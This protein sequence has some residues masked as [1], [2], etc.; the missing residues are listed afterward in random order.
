MITSGKTLAELAGFMTEFPQVLKN[1]EVSK[2]TA[3]SELPK[4]R[5]V[6]DECTKALGKDGRT[7]VRYSGTENKIRVLVEARQATAVELWC[8]KISEVIVQELVDG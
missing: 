6:I 3:I 7:I 1:I 8:N 4:L 5:A 2:K